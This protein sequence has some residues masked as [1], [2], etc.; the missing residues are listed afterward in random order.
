MQQAYGR[1]PVWSSGV[2]VVCALCAWGC[3]GDSS[4]GAPDAGITA[5]GGSS[6]LRPDAS[7]PGSGAGE[8]GSED[9]NGGSGGGSSGSGSGAAGND[10]PDAGSVVVADAGLSPERR[11]CAA[12][13]ARQVVYNAAM[14]CAGFTEEL[15]FATCTSVTEYAPYLGCEAEHTELLNCQ[16]S[17]DTWLCQP[18]GLLDA[19]IENEIV[20]NPSTCPTELATLNSCSP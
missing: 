15:C 4:G 12:M 16:T 13:C 18:S 6:Q 17:A 19:G 11:A 3:D 9:G 20:A 14:P 10:G 1:L 5:N 7:A 2:G 8:G